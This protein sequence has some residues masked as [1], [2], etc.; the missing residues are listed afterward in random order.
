MPTYT[1]PAVIPTSYSFDTVVN[2]K[3]ALSSTS[4]WVECVGN[5]STAT[6]EFGTRYANCS[7][8]GW[9]PDGQVA[10]YNFVNRVLGWTITTSDRLLQRKLP[11]RHPRNPQLYATKIIDAS[12][13]VYGNKLIDSGDNAGGLEPADPPRY[14]S[15]FD[16]IG[17][18]Q[19]ARYGKQQVTIEFQPARWRMLDDS[20]V[21]ST[22]EYARFIDFDVKPNFY[23]VTIQVGNFLWAETATPGPTA[24]TVAS[25]VGEINY[26]EVKTTFALRWRLVPEDFVADTINYP[27][28]PYYS[29][30]SRCAGRVNST[31]FCGYPAGTLLIL[32]PDIER[33][34][35]GTLY[36]NDLSSHKP[37]MYCDVMLPMVHF[38][39]PNSSGDPPVS[40][41][42]GH[43]T[44]PWWAEG[45]GAYAKYYLMTATGN[46][47]TGLRIYSEMDF[48]DIFT[49]W[50]L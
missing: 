24:G 34:V 23:A 4:G 20:Q 41:Y 25:T 46:P 26:L 44:K 31:A 49:H 47:T 1:T 29:K 30:I 6:S 14:T 36:S 10:F 33:Y 17:I 27:Y 45:T 12:G 28:W 39:P 9:I 16:G 5:N 43:N 7:L 19:W 40:G 35:S 11:I 48:N 2:D 15:S 21:V 32:E 22:G 3:P 18:T 42:R 13:R 37:L 8:T 38:D 50:S